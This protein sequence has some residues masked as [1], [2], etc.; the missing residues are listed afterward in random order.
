MASSSIKAHFDRIGLKHVQTNRLTTNQ[1]RAEHVS[2]DVSLESTSL[3]G[4]NSLVL[5]A[6]AEKPPG[7]GVLWVRTGT[8]TQLMFSTDS[9]ETTLSGAPGL[10]ELLAE[11][12]DA[13]SNQISNVSSFN[14]AAGICVGEQNSIDTARPQIAIG[15]GGALREVTGE[16]GIMIGRGTDNYYYA[17]TEVGDLSIAIG[18][19]RA[20]YIPRYVFTAYAS[21]SVAIG[22]DASCLTSNSCVIGDSTYAYS[23]NTNT[24]LI[25]VG[26]NMTQ[27]SANNTILV[28]SVALPGINDACVFGYNS[29]ARNNGVVGFG[30]SLGGISMG[31]PA[32]N[33]AI[34]V[35]ATTLQTPLSTSGSKGALTTHL[36][37]TIGGTAYKIRLFANTGA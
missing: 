15:Q 14:F 17:P 19:A 9:A 27:L 31:V 32:N 10:G 24:S 30:A 21:K 26:S 37:V 12:N 2:A 5:N 28:G 34:R 6:S 8:P 22:R 36:R 16:S 13:D 1:V 29:R 7:N 33:F 3:L 4:G 18:R 23:L 11:T 25:M 20:Q 35:G